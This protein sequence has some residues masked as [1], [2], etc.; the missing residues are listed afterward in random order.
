MAL[1]S[2][3]VVAV[4]VTQQPTVPETLVYQ[5][6]VAEK[7]M[8][9]LSDGSEIFL[10]PK[11]QIEVT[12]TDKQRHI[13]L[14]KGEAFFDVAKN[15]QR[16]FI[17]DSRYTQ[18]KVLGTMFNVNSNS[19]GVTVAVEEGKVQV[20]GLGIPGRLD[21][22]EKLTGGQQVSISEKGLS[23][24][25]LI[26]PENAGAWRQEVRIYQARPLAQVL[27]DLGRYHSAELVVMDE[28]LSLLPITAVF[29]T[30]NVEK[31][32]T[33]LESV[34]PIIVVQTSEERI[35]IRAR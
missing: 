18:V 14:L 15:P 12:F 29:P 30:Q 33:A 7:R 13:K 17:V 23:Q 25:E 5:T 31:M 2:I 21:A 27:E 11:T 6:V 32:L 19:Y 34:L 22:E 24:V 4:V 28:A 9:E 8:L 10:S 26:E 16:P 35:E 1:A 3:L 20:S